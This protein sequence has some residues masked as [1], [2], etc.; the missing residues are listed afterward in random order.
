M[1]IRNALLLTAFITLN[2]FARQSGEATKTSNHELNII[3]EDIFA[4][5]YV[6]PNIYY[7]SSSEYG[8]SYYPYSYYSFDLTDQKITK[9]GLGYKYSFGSSSLRAK[10]SIGFNSSEEEDTSANMSMNTKLFAP[11]IA[12]GYQFHTDMGKVSLFYG[13]DILFEYKKYAVEMERTV[14]RWDNYSG[15]II[16]RKTEQK[17]EY[18]DRSL[19]VSPLFGIQY[20]ITP[21]LSL[22]T[23]LRYAVSFIKGKNKVRIIETTTPEENAETNTGIKTE[24]GPLGQLSI[25]VHF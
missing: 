12:L 17:Y 5:K 1:K 2:A 4:P 24:L 23:E 21:S 14:E 20:Y 7:V 15:S 10:V 9:T 19:G 11:N 8:P 13:A 18:T 16:E 6:Q 3:I 22:S 25:N